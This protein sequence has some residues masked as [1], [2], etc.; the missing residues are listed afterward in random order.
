VE[1]AADRETL[2]VLREKQVELLKG[3]RV[4]KDILDRNGNKFIE[5]G[6]I[7]TE[8]HIQKAQEE[9]PSV[10]VDISMNVDA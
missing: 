7:L 1:E 4:T 3:K 2:Q 5:A 6:T 10:I 9:G 8:E